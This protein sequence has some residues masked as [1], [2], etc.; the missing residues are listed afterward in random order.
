MPARDAVRQLVED[1]FTVREIIEITGKHRVTISRDLGDY[2]EKRRLKLEKK[3]R[4]RGQARYQCGVCGKMGHN[5]RR[6]R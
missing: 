3:R 6:H 2:N 1:G 4:E 5:A